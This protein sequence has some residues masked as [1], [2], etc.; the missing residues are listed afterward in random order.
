[1]VVSR[2]RFVQERGATTA[3][4]RPGFLQ[5]V[6]LLTPM[7]QIGPIMKNGCGRG[8]RTRSFYLRSAEYAEK[9]KGKPCVFPLRP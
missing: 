7:R 1:M 2:H 4:D 8:F 3:V 6:E 9:L 5:L